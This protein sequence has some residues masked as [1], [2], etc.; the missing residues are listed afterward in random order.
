[1]VFVSIVSSLPFLSPLSLCPFVYLFLSISL[2]LSLLLSIP[3]AP[4]L[5]PKQSLPPFPPQARQ[6]ARGDRRA[7]G[8][9]VG[10]AMRR[11]QGKLD[12]RTVNETLRC[13]LQNRF[14]KE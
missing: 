10:C 6:A 14:E 9:L 12:G 8:F 3:F 4:T 2:S 7:M 13:V 5:L 1:M 11:S